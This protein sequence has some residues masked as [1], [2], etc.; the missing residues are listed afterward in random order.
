V[1]R[2]S[3]PNEKRAFSVLC[4]FLMLNNAQLRVATEIFVKAAPM[5]PER[6]RGQG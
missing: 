3:S 5:L 1:Q 6:S 2:T 4:T